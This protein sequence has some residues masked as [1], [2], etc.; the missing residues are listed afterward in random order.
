MPQERRQELPSGEM[1]VYF[2]VADLVD[3][4]HLESRGGVQGLGS[5]QEMEGFLTAYQ[6]WLLCR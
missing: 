2:L 5:T 3:Q 1:H 6:L 4:T